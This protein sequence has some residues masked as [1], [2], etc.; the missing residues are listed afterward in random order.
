MTNYIVRDVNKLIMKYK[1]RNP[2]E[3]A[4]DSNITVKY[5]DLG[6]LK[7]F[8]FYQSRFRYI[9]IN[10]NI[11]NRLKPIICAHELGHERFHQNFAKSKALQE[12]SFFDM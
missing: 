10:E 1:T 9:V 8:Y 7:G 5:N 6:T 4:D 11:K 12:F 3:I 2:F